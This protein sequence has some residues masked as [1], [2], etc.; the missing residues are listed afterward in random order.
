MKDMKEFS[1]QIVAD[2]VAHGF[3]AFPGK[4]LSWSAAYF[5][6]KLV[7]MIAHFEMITGFTFNYH[8]LRRDVEAVKVCLED[9]K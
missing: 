8:S 6:N 9:F 4:P 2:A 3:K 5:N 1:D 7:F